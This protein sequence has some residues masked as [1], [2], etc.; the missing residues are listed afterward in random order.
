MMRCLLD[1]AC[2]CCSLDKLKLDE[3]QVEPE[4][5]LMNLLDANTML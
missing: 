5:Y 4:H 3:F 1:T 2:T